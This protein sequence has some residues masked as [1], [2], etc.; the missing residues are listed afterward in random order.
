MMEAPMPRI[1]KHREYRFEIDAFSPTT[2]PMSRLAEYV[3][4]LAKM[5]GNNNSV[6]LLK[7]DGGSTVPVIMVDWEGEPKVRDRIRAIKS[8]EA[9]EDAQQAARD[10]D[11]H[12]LQVNAKG[13]LLD[14]TGGKV[15]SFLGRENATKMEFG[16]VNQAGV[17]Q[18]VPIKVGGENDPVPVHLEDGKDK[19]IVLARRSL[20]KD[21]AKYL[22]TSV[23]RVEGSGRWIRH[24]DGEWEM[25]SFHATSFKLVED[26]DIRKNINQLRSVPGEWKKLDDPLADLEEIRRGTKL[27]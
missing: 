4:D 19:H 6:H 13:A 27:Q 2:I 12:L 16:P 24:T 26:V 8:R 23:V 21:I 20:A 7:I 9:P 22:F 18:G 1:R 17:F 10:I 5:L 14:P 15:F 11:R 3:S 25:L